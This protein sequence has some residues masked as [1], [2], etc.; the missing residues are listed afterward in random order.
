MRTRAEK[1]IELQKYM[2]L[3][4]GTINEDAFEW[5]NDL[6]EKGLK[7]KALDE[8]ILKCSRCEGLNIKRLSECAC[9]WGDLNADLFFVGQSLHKAGMQTG[10]PFIGGSGYMLDAALR[11][12]GLL[13]KDVFISNTVK[14]HPPGNRQSTEEEK[15]NCQIYLWHELDIVRPKLVVALG[16]DAKATV[17]D[18]DFDYLDDDMPKILCVTHPAKYSYSEPE[19]RYGWIL[20][21]SL[22]IDKVLRDSKEKP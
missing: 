2:N 21:L 18:I 12:S 11:L 9:G 14:C 19:S 3:E 13:R 22:Q 20:K 16:N 7:K 4:T 10:L 17:Q 6:S 1:L 15:K 5:E 8:Q